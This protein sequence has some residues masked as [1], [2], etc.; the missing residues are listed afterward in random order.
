MLW[1]T[2][3]MTIKRMFINEVYGGDYKKYLK[4]RK[5]IIVRY[6]LNGLVS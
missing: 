2:K 5:M 1:R 4:A 3:L 6:S